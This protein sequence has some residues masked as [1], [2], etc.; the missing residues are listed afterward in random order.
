M[1][2]D[3]LHRGA[4][5]CCCWAPLRGG[6]SGRFLGHRDVPWK[7]LW[8][9][10]LLSLFLW[11]SRWEQF[12][13]VLNRPKSSRATPYGLELPTCEPPH[14]FL[15]ISWLAQI[16]PW[17]KRTD[18]HIWWCLW[19]SLPSR[20][21]PNSCPDHP[22]SLSHSWGFPLSN[23]GFWLALRILSHDFLLF[24]LSLV[25]TSIYFHDLK[26]LLHTLLDISLQNPSQMSPPSRNLNPHPRILHFLS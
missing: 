24:G 19:D 22:S 12:G 18:S 13:S 20:M 8:E 25:E 3:C 23:L 6:P 10:G 2:T 5:E 11:S 4:P 15:F 7:G 16:F 9:P 1:L 17:E 14:L 21:F 26:C